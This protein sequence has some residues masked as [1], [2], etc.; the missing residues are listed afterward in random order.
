MSRI[1]GKDTMP[2][3]WC[4]PPRR[5]PLP[6]LHPKT[7]PG[8]PHLVLPT[9]RTLVLVHG[10]FWH[11]RSGCRFAPTVEQVVAKGGIEPP[12]CSPLLDGPGQV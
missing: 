1:R 4:V 9:N 12:T 7:L 6:R 5:L 11:R 8:R 2:S 3:H 10:Y